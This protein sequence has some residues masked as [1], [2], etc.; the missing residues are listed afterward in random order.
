MKFS[1]A[2]L[3]ITAFCGGTLVVGTLMR[4]PPRPVESFDRII[5]LDTLATDGER[6][7]A[8]VVDVN[9]VGAI[10]A[11]EVR[12]LQPETLANA[13][14]IYDFLNEQLDVDAQTPLETRIARAQNLSAMD[15]WIEVNP[16]SFVSARDY[17]ELAVDVTM[18][19]IHA[20]EQ[21][22]EPDAPFIPPRRRVWELSQD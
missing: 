11:M 17:V 7:L 20:D 6:V 19:S 8:F 3:A 15:A 2:L 22:D 16:E 1:H 10:E 4:A 5:S 14:D 12:Q 9:E 18:A 13:T 21:I